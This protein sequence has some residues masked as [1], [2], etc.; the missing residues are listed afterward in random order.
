MALACL[1]SRLKML[2]LLDQARS[3][4]IQLLHSFSKSLLELSAH[5]VMES[6]VTAVLLGL[7]ELVTAGS[8]NPSDHDAHSRGV[9]AILCATQSPLE[10]V[11]GKGLFQLAHSLWRKGPNHIVELSLLPSVQTTKDTNRPMLR[12]DE[13]QLPDAFQESSGAGSEFN[14]TGLYLLLKKAEILLLSQHALS[15][16]INDLLCEAYSWDRDLAR[17]PATRSYEPAEVSKTESQTQSR[18]PPWWP[19][20]ADTYFDLYVA[21]AWNT[22]RKNRLLLLNVIVQCLERLQEKDAHGRKQAEAAGLAK[23][24][25]ASIPFHLTYASGSLRQVSSLNVGGIAVGKTIGGMLLMHPLYVASNL[26]IVPAQLRAHMRECLAWIGGHMG[27]GQASVFSKTSI[28]FP[29]ES[30]I[31]GYVLLWAG[32]LVRPENQQTP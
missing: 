21:A 4:H 14:H 6:L 12:E 10:L 28:T 30:I 15:E 5:D 29:A 2:D 19:P 9:T 22:Y 8:T 23:D 3:L 32:M 24:V 25:L 16:D 20:K 26:P 27:I 7:Y 17:W 13:V 31:H 1:G 11:R 18:R